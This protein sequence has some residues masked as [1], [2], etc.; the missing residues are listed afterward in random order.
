M[1][2]N[3]NQLMAITIA[4]LGVLMVSTAQLTDLFGPAVAKSVVSVAALLNSILGSTLA[5]ITSQG[6]QV[7]DV[8]AMPGVDKID[9][10]AKANKT[11]AAIAVDPSID[12]I[13]P[14]P[15]AQAA[16]AATAQGDSA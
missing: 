10:N 9:I 11:L 1:N 12:K 14:T 16:V 6:G 5:V 2:L 15:A 13:S 7:L 4:V 3:R 8:L